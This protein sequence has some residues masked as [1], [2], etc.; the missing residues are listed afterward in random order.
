VVKILE[1]KCE[2]RVR[3]EVVEEGEGSKLKELKGV[4]RNL[5]RTWSERP[6]LEVESRCLLLL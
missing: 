1:R 6:L 5:K 3:V 4:K 2:G